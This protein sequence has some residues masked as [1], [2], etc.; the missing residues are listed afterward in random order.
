[1]NRR[2][3]VSVHTIKITLIGG[4]V[5]LLLGF[6]HSVHSQSFSSR[7][8]E[9]GLIMLRTI[10]EDIRKNYY[11]P[12]FRGID[13]DARSILAEERIKQAKSNAEVL[14][15]IA[16][17]MLDFNDSHTIFLP[18]QRTARV[19]YGWRMQMFG[20]KCYVIAV[21]PGSDAEAKGIRPGDLV[22]KVDGIAPSRAN[23]WV[24]YYLYTALAPRPAVKLE[25]QS[26]GEESRQLELIAKIKT[27]KKVFDLTDTIDLNA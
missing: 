23:L 26:P 14:G 3:C 1:M 25:V 20:E 9:K 22:K 10:R 21:K 6:S 2:F 5:S 24:Y 18:P 17:V 7:D 11:N 19:D 12:S 15:I 27:G 8:R 13:L 4:C 16:Q